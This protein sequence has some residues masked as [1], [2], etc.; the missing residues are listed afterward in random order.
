MCVGY[1]VYVWEV[2]H[3]REKVRMYVWGGGKYMWG[4]EDV[5]VGRSSVCV[6]R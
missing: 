5:C 3:M 2:K 6:G 4:R 1:Q